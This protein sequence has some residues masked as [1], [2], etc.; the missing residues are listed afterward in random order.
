MAFTFGGASYT[1]PSSGQSIHDFNTQMMQNASYGAGS[2]FGSGSG[3]SAALSSGASSIQQLLDLQKQNNAWSASQAADLRKWQESQNKLAMD[4][5]A[6]EAAKNRN[7]QQMM[8]STAHQREVADLKAAGLNPI[9]SA[10]GGNGAAVGSGAT[11][12]GV[13]SSGAKGDTD[14]S[15]SSAIAGLFS[16]MWQQQT[17]MEVARLNAQ[18][19][20]AIA[21]RNNAS[22]ELIAQIAGAF[23]NER[24]HIAGQYGLSQAAQHASA[25]QAAALIAALA[26]TA[27]TTTQTTSARDIQILKGE[28]EEYLRKYY[29]QSYAGI[30][31]GGFQQILDQLGFGKRKGTTAPFGSSGRTGSGSFSGGHRDNM[32]R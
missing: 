1:G 11:A 12:S 8:S 14:T 5:N 2:S 28:Q 20:Q 32:K 6:A 4:F 15:T 26:S 25:T 16:A 21:E 9:L 23:G 10:M 7:W 27:N 22:A 3:G 18:S 31:S 19:N 17:Q 24:A 29:P 30:V 13:T